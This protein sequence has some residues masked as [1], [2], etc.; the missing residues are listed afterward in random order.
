M[1]NSSPSEV[2]DHLTFFTFVRSFVV[3]TKESTVFPTA[4][5]STHLIVPLSL[6]RMYRR[7]GDPARCLALYPLKHRYGHPHR[8]LRS[9][10]RSTSGARFFTRPFS[11]M[12]PR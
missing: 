12:H 3:E 6:M 1:R 11:T 8:H 5:A 4:S 9:G 7:A 2:G 10:T